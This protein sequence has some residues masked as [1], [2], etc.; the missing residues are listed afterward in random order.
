[1]NVKY[2]VPVAVF[3]AAMSSFAQTLAPTTVVTTTGTEAPAAEEE[4]EAPPVTAEEVGG[5]VEAMGEA[6]TELRNIVEA[7]NK[8]KISGYVQGQ[9]VNDEATVNELSGTGTRNRDQ[10]SVRRGRI[11][12]VYTANPSSR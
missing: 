12:L 3:A 6:F 7:L 8:L 10:F 5:R 11:K 9:Y 2:L 4:T 1:M